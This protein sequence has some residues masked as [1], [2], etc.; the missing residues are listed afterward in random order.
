MRAFYNNKI[1]YN[2]ITLQVIANG[3]YGEYI[4]HETNDATKSRF[5]FCQSTDGKN[6]YIV[7]KPKSLW[8]SNNGEDIYGRTG[9][10]IQSYPPYKSL[11][12]IKCGFLTP[13]EAKDNSSG[14]ELKVNNIVYNSV[15]LYDLNE[16]ARNRSFGTSD[17]QNDQLLFSR[18]L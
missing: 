9:A 16:A 15:T 4:K 5:I 7:L 8:I 3:S 10:S 2:Y 18:W 14:L 17:N 12:S 11:E 6:I 13:D 1:N